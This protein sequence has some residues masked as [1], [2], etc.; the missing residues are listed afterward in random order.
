MQVGRGGVSTSGH[1][2]PHGHD[3]F[4]SYPDQLSVYA[5]LSKTNNLLHR[6]FG[7]STTIT[8][9]AIN[10]VEL[11]IRNSILC[12]IFTRQGPHPWDAAA[13]Q[14]A[15]GADTDISNDSSPRGYPDFP[16]SPDSWLGEPSSAHY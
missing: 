7:N 6:L 4:S 16:P 11:N 8:C 2:P 13:P 14:L 12:A 1:T 9:I 15:P 3:H 5:S 10:G